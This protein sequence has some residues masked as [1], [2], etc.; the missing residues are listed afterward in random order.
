MTPPPR[1]ASGMPKAVEIKT[2]VLLHKYV[3]VNRDPKKPEEPKTYEKGDVVTGSI[4]MPDFTGQT[5]KVQPCILLEEKYLIPLSVLQEKKA[6][7]VLSPEVDVLAQ[8]NAMKNDESF[9]LGAMVGGGAGVIFGYW[10]GKSII[11][12]AVIGLMIGGL[13]GHKFFKPSTEAETAK[14]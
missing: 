3:A 9:K 8:A 7:T 2:Y 10:T 11:L 6:D 1:Q 4:V 14:A 13:V 12:S 5:V